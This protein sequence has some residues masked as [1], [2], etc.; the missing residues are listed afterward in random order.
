M[1]AD[2]EKLG[3]YGVLGLDLFASSG[4]KIKRA[5]FQAAKRFH[6]DRHFGLPEETK[7]KLTEIF[8]YI[9]NAYITLSDPEKKCEYDNRVKKKTAPGGFSVIQ[10]GLDDSYKGTSE[11]K[12]QNVETGRSSR[13]GLKRSEDSLRMLLTLCLGD[14]FLIR[15]SANTLH[16]QCLVMLQRPKEAVA[17]LNR[18]LETDRHQPDVLSELGHAYVQLGFPLRAEGYFEKALKLHSILS[19]KGSRGLASLK[20]RR[21]V[22]GRAPARDN[23][24]RIYSA[25]KQ[26]KHALRLLPYSC[27]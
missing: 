16:H 20:K 23:I 13:R 27:T 12:A 21:R 8:T 2:Y 7:T 25:Y 5:Y 6:P 18:A 26:K 4:E 10:E 22:R 3:Y 24:G 1:H 15:P 14:L 17:A 9:T 11:Q 19:Q